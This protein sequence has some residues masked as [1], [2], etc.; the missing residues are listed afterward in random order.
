MKFK[1]GL[2]FITLITLIAS[3]AFKTTA[4]ENKKFS[5]D[6]VVAVVGNSIILY[7][8]VEEARTQLM[9]ERRSMGYTLD[10]DPT[11]EALELL[12]EQK[13]LYNQALIDSIEINGAHVVQM[14]EDHVA[15]LTKE[16]GGVAEL[17]AMFHRPIFEIKREITYRLEESEYAQTMMG[18]ITRDVN[19]TPGEVERY[20]NSLDKDSLPMIPIQYI[21]G[22]ITRFPLSTKEAKLR[23]REQ[24]LGIREQII[25]GTRFETLARLYSEDGSAVMGGMLDPGPIAQWETNFGDAVE[26]LRVGQV[27][28]IVE[29][30]FGFHII[31][32]LDREGDIYH[33]R[34]ILLRPKF[35]DDE[36]YETSEMLDSLAGKIR[37]DSISFERAA[38]Q[39]SDD[40]YSRLNG[41]LVS[42]L[43]AME[44]MMDLE[45]SSATT[46]HF[47]ENLPAE[48]FRALDRLQPGEISDAFQ[49]EDI[50][51]NKLSKV[52]KLIEII[53]SHPASLEDD[54]LRLEQM[55]LADKKQKK[56]RQ[57]LN[58]K[59]R[60][61]FIR[62]SP[63][64]VNEEEFENETWLK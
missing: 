50:K 20:F 41:G 60:T 36:L 58:Q 6:K 43:E 44:Y 15:N 5:V 63:E 22:Q 28:E 31:E 30:S 33:A 2:I 14:A 51:G 54:Y 26:R 27:S 16:M 37:A 40:K 11:I 49:A 21:Y 55:A 45:A 8:D 18:T 48:D 59:I 35:T 13:L 53:P 64:F 56:Y 4:G 62:I 12:M 38:I 19:I 1:R 46:K 52:V 47:K 10:R 25:G 17:E 29:T 24:L 32:L 7:S 61:M 23:T 3:A 34:H 42:N 39:H 9:S 57:W